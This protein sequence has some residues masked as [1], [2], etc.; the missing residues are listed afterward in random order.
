VPVAS[1]D[2]SRVRPVEACRADSSPLAD[3]TTPVADAPG[4]TGA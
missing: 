2:Q 4:V 1:L 3:A